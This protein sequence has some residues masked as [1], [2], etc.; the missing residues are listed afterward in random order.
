[1]R[2]LLVLLA[3]TG[4][5]TIASAG[6]R[7]TKTGVLDLE[8]VASGGNYVLRD[9]AFEVTFTG[10]PS[11][12][13]DQL[14]AA[15]GTDMTFASATLDLGNR[16]L[17]F[18]ILPSPRDKAYDAK[19]GLAG[20]RDMSIARMKGKLVSETA[21]KIDGHDG[22]HV[23]ATVVVQG[24]TARVDEYMM[25]DGEHRMAVLLMTL[26][27]GTVESDEG[28]AFVASYKHL[29]SSHSPLDP[30][31]PPDGV[32]V[33][34]GVL[35]FDLVRNVSAYTLRDGA[36]E[37]TLP[38]RPTVGPMDID[39]GK[40]V[41]AETALDEVDSVHAAL[42]FLPPA[43]P[44]DA[45]K[46]ATAFRDQLLAEFKR[47]KSKNKAVKLAGLDGTRTTFTGSLKGKTLQGEI[48]IVWSPKHHML[49]AIY[50]YTGG[51]KLTAGERAF[52]D[53]LVVHADG[54]PPV[55]PATK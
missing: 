38:S 5:S 7:V 43:T 14:Q 17:M 45:R 4:L 18:G 27:E 35:D 29:A 1:M 36:V 10:K 21:T 24:R 15:D 9:G 46:A 6:D 48:N 26:V 47:V 30:A 53:S 41:F 25:W 16:Y 34:T 52:L 42:F 32:P 11:V 13:S 39:P 55:L 31:L 37:V 28:K 22:R 12:S 44:Y 33:A 3:V 49:V 50:A 51:K 20:A 54:K 8:L 40:G 23:V 2:A 19:T